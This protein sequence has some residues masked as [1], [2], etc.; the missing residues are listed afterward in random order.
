[1]KRSEINGYIKNAIGFLKENKFYLPE[2]AEWTV[3]D[4]RQKKDDCLRLIECGLGWDV[5]DYGSNDFEKFGCVI[6]TIRNGD[7]T[8]PAIKMPYA[9]KII[10][11]LPGQRL[12]M[13]FHFKKEEDIINRGNGVLVLELYNSKED[14][15]IDYD[16]PVE[17]YCDGIKHIVSPGV[18]F[19]IMPGSS[20][21]ISPY[22]YHMFYADKD[23]G[24][25]LCGEV[26]SVNDDY[27]DNH[28]NEKHEIVRFMDILEDEKPSFLLCNEYDGFL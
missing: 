18:P 24:T 28:H 1:M 23:S 16:S 15:S 20:I 25:L 2:F 9:E 8:N 26:S 13:H 22:L 11:L 14:K 4:W 12:P 7:Y 19:K 5:T 6:F 3:D 10:H 17:V 21:T 27:N